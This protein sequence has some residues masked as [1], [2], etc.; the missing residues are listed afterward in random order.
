MAV[1]PLLLGIFALIA[2]VVIDGQQEKNMGNLF[3]GTFVVDATTGECISP[4]IFLW[5]DNAGCSC[6][7]NMTSQ[8]IVY[9]DTVAKRVYGLT[10]CYDVTV[11]TASVG[12]FAGIYVESLNNT[13]L[14]A[15]PKSQGCGCYFAN[16]YPSPTLINIDISPS[17]N[18]NGPFVQ[19]T[20]SWCQQSWPSN[21]YGGLIAKQHKCPPGYRPQAAFNVSDANY[22]VCLVQCGTLST[23]EWC[24]DIPYCGWCG[25]QGPN[26]WSPPGKCYDSSQ[27]VC[28]I[29]Y[30]GTAGVCPATSTCCNTY[31]AVGCCSNSNSE[32]CSDGH[33]YAS[34]Q[35]PGWQSCSV[36]CSG[37]FC[38][39]NTVCPNCTPVNASAAVAKK[40]LALP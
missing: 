13:C 26:S 27:D 1:I 20:L 33:S 7:A 5:G 2:L 17:G 21:L 29:T 10:V 35:P 16:I 25:N 19:G 4:N 31:Y 34:C 15:N 8:S 12:S 40:R 3:Q 32:C 39:P 14:S 30:G 36:G 11:Q 38:P 23:I 9:R 22:S 37:T 24:G 6:A 18:A 28:C